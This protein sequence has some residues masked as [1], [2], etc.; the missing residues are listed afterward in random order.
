M[1]LLSISF[2]VPRVSSSSL[3]LL[4]WGSLDCSVSFR[5]WLCASASFSASAKVVAVQ[6]GIEFEQA[7]RW[8]S[9]LCES[10]NSSSCAF[11]FPRL[12]FASY[13]VHQTSQLYSL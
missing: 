11:F 10:N 9:L 5:F 4:S 2:T 8:I 12:D 3:G 1:L 6:F 13:P 7:P